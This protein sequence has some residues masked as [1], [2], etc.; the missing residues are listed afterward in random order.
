METSRNTMS[1]R[2]KSYEPASSIDERNVSGYTSKPAASEA[3]L[4]PSTLLLNHRQRQHA[5][6]LLGLP[7]HHLDKSSNQQLR[8]GVGP[9]NKALESPLVK[10]KGY[11]GV[12]DSKSSSRIICLPASWSPR[13]P[14][15]EKRVFNKSRASSPV[16]TEKGVSGLQI[17][18]VR[19]RLS[20][21]DNVPACYLDSEITIPTKAQIS[22]YVRAL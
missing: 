14:P 19:H 20:V 12:H 10:R 13:S 8:Y 18:V 6:R 9:F 5:C 16:S 3:A 17:K 15:R 2:T 11:H 4:V 7:D 22:I 21:K 1:K